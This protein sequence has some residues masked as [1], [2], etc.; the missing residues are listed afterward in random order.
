M[1]TI[2]IKNTS[3]YPDNAVRWLIH[4]AARYVRSEFERMG[5]LERFDRSGFYV[6]FKNKS[7][8]TY[9]GRYFNQLVTA[10]GAYPFLACETFR[11]MLVKIGAPEKF[12]MHSWD[13][14]FK[15]MPEGDLNDWQEATVAIAAHEFCHVKYS[16]DKAGEEACDTIM[17]DAVTAFRSSRQLFNEAMDAGQRKDQERQLAIAAKKSPESVAKQNLTDAESK[18]AKWN[19]KQKLATTKVKFY[20]RLVNRAARK[21]AELAIDKMIVASGKELKS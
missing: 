15:D 7:R 19:R 16:G 13:S 18:L 1:K 5:F 11:R 10:Q 21:T 12:P 9:S 20:T 4:F 2:I 17:H 14:R 6:E 3:R 8:A